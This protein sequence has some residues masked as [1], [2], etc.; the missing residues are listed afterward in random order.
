MEKLGLQKAKQNPDQ[1]YILIRS[2][3]IFGSSGSVIE[4]WV[5][6]IKERNEITITNPNMTRF[7]T[8]VDDLVK[9]IIGVMGKGESGRIYIPNQKAIRLEDLVNA[10][11]NLVGNKNVKMRIVGPRMGERLH[12]DLYKE[13]EP[14]VTDLLNKSSQD[15]EKMNMNEILSLY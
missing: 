15:A 4:K 9:F 11:I 13:G 5:E 1:K 3:N 7:F 14:V 8:H 12:E 2:G 6:Q 10:T